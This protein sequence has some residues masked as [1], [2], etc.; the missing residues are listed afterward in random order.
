MICQKITDSPG[1]GEGAGGGAAEVRQIGL[2]AEAGQVADKLL[3][4]AE[5]QNYRPGAQPGQDKSDTDGNS[6]EEMKQ[7]VKAPSAIDFLR[8]PGFYSPAG[9]GFLFK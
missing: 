1:P 6:L 3:V 4:K 2:Q 8:H 7:H 5:D 9:S